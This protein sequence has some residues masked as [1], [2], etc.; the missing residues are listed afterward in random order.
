MIGTTPGNLS[1]KRPMF[2][3]VDLPSLD[4]LRLE[5]AGNIG[6]TG[7]DSE[8]LT[9]VSSSSRAKVTGAETGATCHPAG[10]RSATLA[11]APPF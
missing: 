8:N 1:A 2:V 5:G 6:V 9:V 10:A 4:R 7:V 3:E 11:V